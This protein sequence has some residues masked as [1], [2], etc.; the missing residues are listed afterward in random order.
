MRDLHEATLRAEA[1]TTA[2]HAVTGDIPSYIPQ[3][4]G[5]QR[6]HNASRALK[7]AR[8]EMMTA[9]NRLNEFLEHGIVPDDLK[10]SG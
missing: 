3:P 10:R 7:V 2:F 6:I 1:A 4:D 8:D 5:T 9:H